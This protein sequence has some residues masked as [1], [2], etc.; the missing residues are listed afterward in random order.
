MVA[1]LHY[2]IASNSMR[3]VTPKSFLST[4]PT[5]H[6]QLGIQI[7]L[8]PMPTLST[9]PTLLN[10]PKRNDCLT[11]NA[12]IRTDH[13]HLQSLRN[14]PNPAHIPREEIP[15]Q[16]NVS[17]VSQPH[18]LVLRLELGQGSEWAESLLGVDERIGRDI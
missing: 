17:I 2:Y 3:L 13:T 18:D 1:P 8:N 15:S 5:K 16:P 11:D 14:A 10:S 12:S 7:I 9:Q 6:D 4:Q